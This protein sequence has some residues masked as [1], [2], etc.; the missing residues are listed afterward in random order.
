LFFFQW[1]QDIRE[2]VTMPDGSSIP[3]VLLANKSDLTDNMIQTDIIGRYC[4]EYS[5]G[6]WF[7]TSAKE[8]INIGKLFSTTEF[9]KLYQCNIVCFRRG[10]ELP[11]GA[12]FGAEGCRSNKRLD[13]FARPVLFQQFF[14]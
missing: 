14:T 9:K 5:I 13:S 2:K 11:G 4:R 3:I 1:I 6:A 12:G 8:N 7:I 10:N